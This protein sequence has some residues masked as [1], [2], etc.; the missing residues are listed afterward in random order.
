[1][2]DLAQQRLLVTEDQHA[3]PALFALANQLLPELALNLRIQLGS[4]LI[5]DK[6]PSAGIEGAQQRGAGQLATGELTRLATEPLGLDHK[7]GQHGLI[8]APYI[9]QRLPCGA[10]GIE[11]QFWVLGHQLDG[12][13]TFYQQRHRLPI[14]P[15]FPASPNQLPTRQYPPQRGFAITAGGRDTEPFARFHRQRQPL[16]EGAFSLGNG[17]IPYFKHQETSGTEKS[18]L[19]SGSACQWAR[20]ISLPCPWRRWWQLKVSLTC[21]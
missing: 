20:S 18:V 2:A 16:P 11:G 17:E 15:H 4:H 6:Q 5:G 13:I 1:M 8:G 3:K 7:A 19:N 14:Q 21:P 10:I 12:V 9:P